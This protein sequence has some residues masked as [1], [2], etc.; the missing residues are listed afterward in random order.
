MLLKVFITFLNEQSSFGDAEKTFL[1]TSGCLF[2]A[3]G[4]GWV[5]SSRWGRPGG[6]FGGSR[7]VPEGP[8]GSLGSLG[9]ALG[10]SWETLGVPL[11]CPWRP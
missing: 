11:G 3:L 8:L 6:D 5:P 4:E 10:V 9:G 7:G 1:R 2:E